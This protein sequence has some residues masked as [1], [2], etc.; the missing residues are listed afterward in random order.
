MDELGAEGQ[1]EAEFRAGLMWIG[2]AWM[3]PPPGWAET[4]EQVCQD[5]AA[6]WPGWKFYGGKRDKAWAEVWRNG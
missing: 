4:V 6:G 2:P 3:G 5:R 1:A